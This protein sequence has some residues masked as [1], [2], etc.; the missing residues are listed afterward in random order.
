MGQCL[1]TDP[2]PYTYQP[3]GCHEKSFRS[4]KCEQRTKGQRAGLS[5]ILH[6]NRMEKERFRIRVHVNVENCVKFVQ[7]QDSSPFCVRTKTKRFMIRVHGNVEK[8]QY[9]T[10]TVEP[11]M[12]PRTKSSPEESNVPYSTSSTQIPRNRLPDTRS[13]R[14]N[15]PNFNANSACLPRT[16]NSFKGLRRLTPWLSLTL[17]LLRSL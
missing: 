11:S 10:S 8:M 2:Y 14:N 12:H 4:S 6:S 9:T 7:S 16:G 1:C 17:R 5:T 15:A 13:K 3:R